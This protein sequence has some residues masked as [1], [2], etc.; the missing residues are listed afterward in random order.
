MYGRIQLGKGGL[1]RR[2][3]K[4][5]KEK[6][7]AQLNTISMFMLIYTH[8]HNGSAT[9]FFYHCKFHLRGA[10]KMATQVIAQ[11]ALSKDSS[12]ILR[13]HKVGHGQL[14]LQFHGI[15]RPL[16]IFVGTGHA[17]GTQRYMQM[18]TSTCDICFFKLISSIF[19]TQGGKKRFVK[20]WII[21][22]QATV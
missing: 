17:S 9:W 13:I 12:S 18:K 14:K 3:N 22:L 7:N 2:T 19:Q 8:G 1:T 15:K 10:G 16:L 5:I 11:A 4:H 21:S 6:E 20:F